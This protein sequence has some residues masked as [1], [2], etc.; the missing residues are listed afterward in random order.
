MRKDGIGNEQIHEKL[1]VMP[2]EDK[3]RGMVQIK[4]IAR[5]IKNT[6]LRYR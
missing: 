2:I 3:M 4:H 6:W 1:G 5:T